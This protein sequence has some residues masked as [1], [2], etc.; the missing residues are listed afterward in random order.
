MTY[1]EIKES[2]RESRRE[3]TRH[4][5]TLHRVHGLRSTL[6]HYKTFDRY[7]KML[8]SQK[9]LNEED[10]ARLTKYQE[11]LKELI[12]CSTRLDELDTEGGHSNAAHHLDLFDDI[13]QGDKNYKKNNDSERERLPLPVRKEFKRFV[14]GLHTFLRQAPRK[15]KNFYIGALEKYSDNA[16]FAREED[17]HGVSIVIRVRRKSPVKPHP[18]PTAP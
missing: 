13:V 16:S 2:L 15:N 4:F 1:E 6:N 8:E 11:I 7:E 18:L 9:T 5:E 17:E 12:R 14:D 10:H 3:L